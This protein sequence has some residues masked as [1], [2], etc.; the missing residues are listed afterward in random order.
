MNVNI[1]TTCVFGLQFVK[2]LACCLV[3]FYVEVSLFQYLNHSYG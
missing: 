1:K 2:S 3:V